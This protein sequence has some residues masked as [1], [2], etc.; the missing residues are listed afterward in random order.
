MEEIELNDS[1]KL[2]GYV[3]N[4]WCISSFHDEWNN[5]GEIT[6]GTHDK[7]YISKNENEYKKIPLCYLPSIK[8][9]FPLYM[10]TESPTKI[11][12]G[13]LVSH[14]ETLEISEIFSRE[15]HIPTVDFAYPPS[16]LPRLKI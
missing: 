3:T 4:S 5:N 10:K 16:K 9:P 7:Q 2:K 13:K 8:F 15:N 6:I 11:F 12:T 14:P 1:S